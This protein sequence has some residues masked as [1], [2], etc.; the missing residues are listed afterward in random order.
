MASTK[1]EQAKLVGDWAKAQAELEKAQEAADKARATAQG[2]AR[3]LYQEFGTE[4]FS[5][6]AL[7]RKYRCIHKK[8][9]TNKHGVALK[10]V[11]AVL[12]LA[13]NEPTREF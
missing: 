6:K 7:G 9:T 2:F 4:P 8:P 12:P 3:S 5:V 10:E 11:Y 1:A 13:E